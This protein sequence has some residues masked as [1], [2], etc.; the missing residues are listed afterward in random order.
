MS[1]EQDSIRVRASDESGELHYRVFRRADGDRVLFVWNR[2]VDQQVSIV[3][4]DVR[5]ATE[6]ALDGAARPPGPVPA[7]VELT[8]GI[9]RVF[10]LR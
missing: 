4:S 7:T 5:S 8:R 2:T 3:T 9:P 10:R 1:V 6:Y